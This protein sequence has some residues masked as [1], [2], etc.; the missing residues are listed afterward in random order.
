MASATTFRSVPPG[1]ADV[2]AHR[3]ADLRVRF[4]GTLAAAM[5]VVDAL[6]WEPCLDDASFSTLPLRVVELLCARALKFAPDAFNCAFFDVAI[7]ASKF[8]E[9]LDSLCA[10]GLS[11][12]PD[13]TLESLCG[14][15]EH[16][17]A[18]LSSGSPE[19]TVTLADLFLLPVQIQPFPSPV[20]WALDIR[21]GALST[22]GPGG[23]ATPYGELAF[24][25]ANRYTE[26]RAAPAGASSLFLNTY[27]SIVVAEQS[28]LEQL[29][30]I[31]RSMA[32]VDKFLT[33]LWEPCMRS[34]TL[35][36]HLML[37]DVLNRNQ[38][39]SG[40]AR[41]RES[42]LAQRFHTLIEHKENLSLVLGAARSPYSFG[43]FKRLAKA[44]VSGG[45]T[46]EP[47]AIAEVEEALVSWVSLVKTAGTAASPSER[48][49]MIEAHKQRAEQTAPSG[50]SVSDNDAPAAFTRGNRFGTERLLRS[51]GFLDLVA[52]IN[53]A[54]RAAQGASLAFE[55][56]S[57]N[58]LVLLDT[59]ALDPCNLLGLCFESGLRAIVQFIFSKSVD[60]SLHEIFL[61]LL[62]ARKRL[63]D[64]LFLA[65]GTEDD[66]VPLRIRG[67]TLDTA[68]V[69]LI[70]NGAFHKLDLASMAANVRSLAR[71]GVAITAPVPDAQRFADYEKLEQIRQSGSKLFTALGYNELLDSSFSVVISRA[72]DLID[73]SPAAFRHDAARHA[74]D[75]IR[76]ALL[77][78]G[79]RWE[80]LLTSGSQGPWPL[81]AANDDP[82]KLQLD[83][84]RLARRGLEEMMA[85]YPVMQSLLASSARAI[86]PA[87]QPNS[88]LGANT[89]SNASKKRKA[90]DAAKAAGGGAGG[91]SA[92][93]GSSALAPGSEF[94][95]KVTMVLGTSVTFHRFDPRTQTRSPGITYNIDAIATKLGINK[96]SVCWPYALSRSR[97]DKLRLAVCCDHVAH[98]TDSSPHSLPAVA[99]VLAFVN[100][101]GLGAP[102]IS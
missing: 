78:A 30:S 93:G 46:F 10:A 45:D 51:E 74:D 72:M 71:E 47:S 102:Y 75:Y 33:S 17:A 34:Y 70:R 4:S 39:L 43:L 95:S 15:V 73:R 44:L 57:A 66:S 76:K 14:K 69:A 94:G 36:S 16:V 86:P 55:S 31:V 101:S 24:L 82:A 56:A 38:F 65:M 42:V 19:L 3:G 85:A 23:P 53:S 6:P 25:C 29:P 88:A 40:D 54:S 63:G 62:S 11:F 2:S 48:V 81:F 68:T 9:V 77:H 64:Y 58:P 90:A 26:N 79:Q 96:D 27:W 18:L 28:H 37:R 21:L 7:G 59:A 52:K 5:L 41:C 12:E 97:S 60:T 49:A 8:A 32:V 83:G 50:T 61:L 13:D 89:V 35:D 67:H 22:G 1:T 80:A 84:I 92:V 99:K 98:A 91:S 20:D 87:A 100:T